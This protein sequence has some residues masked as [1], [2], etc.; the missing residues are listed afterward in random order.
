VGG[1]VWA[2]SGVG[3]DS[4]GKVVR[5]SSRAEGPRTESYRKVPPTFR[6]NQ[7]ISILHTSYSFQ[8]PVPNVNLHF[9]FS[10][11]GLSSISVLEQKCYLDLNQYFQSGKQ[12]FAYVAPPP[13]QEL[14]R[15]Q[16]KSETGLS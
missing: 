13:P 4:A 10:A 8:K 7:I 1:P 5:G 2:L 11:Y 6:F 12:P 9:L 14:G 16:R 3:Q 15:T